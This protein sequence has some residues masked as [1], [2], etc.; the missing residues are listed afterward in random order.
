MVREPHTLAYFLREARSSAR[1]LRNAIT[2]AS[3]I[4]EATF[5]NPAI[6]ASSAFGVALAFGVAFGLAFAVAFGFADTRAFLSASIADQSPVARAVTR[7]TSLASIAFARFNH[8]FLWTERS[9]ARARAFAF[10]FGFNH[11]L[12]QSRMLGFQ[13]VAMW[14]SLRMRVKPLLRACSTQQEEKSKIEISPFMSSFGMCMCMCARD[15]GFSD[16]LLTY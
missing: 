5:A 4:C 14:L 10:V 12:A 8:A 11:A 16:R 7:A 9:F 2:W 6:T 13:I 3:V 1:T 15:D